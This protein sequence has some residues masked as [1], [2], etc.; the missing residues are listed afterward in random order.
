V[1]ELNINHGRLFHWQVVRSF[2]LQ[3]QYLYPLAESNQF[4]QFSNNQ[5]ILK[6][7]A[8]ELFNSHSWCHQMKKHS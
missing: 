8:Y 7:N 1:K 4:Q 5:W 6:R 3:A 2:Q